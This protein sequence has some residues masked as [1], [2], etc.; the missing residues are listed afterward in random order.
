LARVLLALVLLSALTGCARPRAAPPPGGHGNF[1]PAGR[2]ETAAPRF[3]DVTAAA[4]IHFRHASG[5]SGAKRMPE[6]LGSGCAFWDYNGDGRLDLLLLNGRPLPDRGLP[7][8]GGQSAIRDPQSAIRTL[9]LYRN[10]GDGTFTDVT[11]AAGLALPMYAMGCAAADYDNDGDE[12]LYVTCVLGPSHLFRNQGNGTFVDVTRQAGVANDGPGRWGTSCAWLDYDRDGRLDLF[13]ANYVRY[14]PAHEVRCTAPGGRPNYCTPEHYEPQVS[15]L[16]HN[17]GG[18][19]FRDVTDAS[20]IGRVAGK[21]LGVVVCDV[22]RDGNP[23]LYVANDTTRNLLFHNTG[24]GTFVEEGLQRGLAYA[25]TGQ[26]RAGMGVDED[27]PWNDGRQAFAVSNFAGEGLTLFRQ[28]Q[29]DLFLD[30]SLTT[31]L[32]EP[33]LR[34]LGFGLLFLDAS[35]SLRPEIFVANGHIQSDIQEQQPTLRYRQPHQLFQ[36]G[37]DGVFR[38]VGP[39]AGPAFMVGRVSRGAAYGDYDNDGDLDLLVNNNNGAPELLRNEGVPGRHWLQVS[40]HGTASNRDALGAEVILRAEGITRR[41]RVRTGSSYCSQSMLPLHF[42]L[43]TLTRVDSLEILWPSGRVDRRG[44]LP[45][46]TR[47][48]LVEGR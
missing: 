17:E 14:D 23:D 28:E 1:S 46:D 7:D 21:A 10:S 34:T 29:P 38:D 37:D 41:R 47:L 15:R 35:N 25:E 33:T 32:H 2:S 27:E 26:P 18:G 22:D 30:A 44:N 31:G 40:L 13:V 36:S 5:A 43:G 16:Y 6:P 11:R 42:G 48:T 8:G 19:R 4:G 24:R 45:V 9:A 3:T 20:G 12:D 39:R